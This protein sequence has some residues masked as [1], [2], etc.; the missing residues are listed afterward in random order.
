MKDFAIKGVITVIFAG[1][2]AYFHQL[3]GPV[4]V[5]AIVMAADYITGVLAASFSG[6]LSSRV[7]LLARK[8]VMLLSFSQWR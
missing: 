2:A 5:L 4:I 7:G 1:A 6:T 8:T 3:L